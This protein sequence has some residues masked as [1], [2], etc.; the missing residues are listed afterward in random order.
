MARAWYTASVPLLL[1]LACLWS[2]PA[3]AQEPAPATP[4]AAEAPAAPVAEAASSPALSLDTLLAAKKL[5]TALGGE[6][7][8]TVQAG[9]VANAQ[10]QLLGIY[11]LGKKVIHPGP[12][13]V[14]PGVTVVQG[15]DQDRGHLPE[16]V[17]LPNT[18]ADLEAVQAG[19]HQVQQDQVGEKVSPFR[20]RPGRIHC[21]FRHIF[22]HRF[23]IP[24]DHHFTVHAGK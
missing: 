20:I 4:P 16:D 15:G 12:E 18:A 8:E 14:E 22:Q 9:D 1:A 10:S 11:R 7:A 19:Q 13:A 3:G 6:V 21:T 2:V 17:V 23:A 24:E 5:A